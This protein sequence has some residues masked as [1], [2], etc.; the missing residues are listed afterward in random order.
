MAQTLLLPRRKIHIPLCGIGAVKARTVRAVMSIT[1]HSQYHKSFQ[2][3]CEVLIL[4]K[5]TGLLPPTGLQI[6]RH[7]YYD[8]LDL[9]D[10]HYYESAKIDVLL[11]ATVYNAIICSGVLRRPDTGLI[12][13]ETLLGWIVSGATEYNRSRRAEHISNKVT[14]AMYCTAEEKLRQDLQRLWILEEVEGAASRLS[15]EEEKSEEM[16][17]NGYSRD[18]KGR[19]TVRLPFIYEPHETIQKTRLIAQR[20]LAALERRLS[21]NLKL[22]EEYHRFMQIYELMGHME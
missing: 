15:L 4:S 2:M 18:E 6:T 16:F 21:R 12:A 3:D 20:S 14:I 22:N 9:A 7:K 13:Q 19:Y 10:P 1:L 17:K 8:N 5:L 11:G